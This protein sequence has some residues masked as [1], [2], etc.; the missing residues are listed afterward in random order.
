MTLKSSDVE[1]IAYLARLEINT[2]DIPAY[3]ENLSHILEFVAQIDRVDVSGITPISHPLGAYQ[4]LRPDEVTEIDRREDFQV[5]APSV[6]A[7][8]YLVPKVIE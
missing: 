8:V 5:N 3:T 6:E 2:K 4:R 1:R 7:G